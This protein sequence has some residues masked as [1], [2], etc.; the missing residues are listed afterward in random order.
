MTTVLLNGR[1]LPHQDWEGDD[2]TPGAGGG[3]VTC[4]DTALGRDVAYATNGRIVLD[5]RVYRSH[6]RP[7]DPNGITLPQARQACRSATGLS[8]VIPPDWKWAQVLAHL[9]AKK[10][11]IV[12]GWYSKIPS[13]YRFQTGSDFAHAMWISHYSP[14]AGMRVWDPLD[15]NRTHHGQW[16]PARHIRAFMEELSRRMNTT[17]LYVGYVP[18]QHL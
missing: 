1:K 5:G 12:Q 10:G 9:T 6:V 2:F 4:T 11:A 3:Y 7:P 8:L 14:T 18:L 16:V 15:R 17:S 13:D